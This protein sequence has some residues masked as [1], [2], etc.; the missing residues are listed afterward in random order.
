[1]FD[2]EIKRKLIE[3]AK[4]GKVGTKQLSRTGISE[5][6]ITHMGNTLHATW[7]APFIFGRGRLRSMALNGSETTLDS[8]DNRDVFT[9]MLDRADHIW[10][11][12]AAKVLKSIA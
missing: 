2:K 12:D 7:Y 4:N 5:L 11:E 1:M 6:S 3:I 8:W 9:A 10:L